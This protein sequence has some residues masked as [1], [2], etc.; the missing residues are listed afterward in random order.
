M[1]SLWEVEFVLNQIKT[2]KDDVLIFSYFYFARICNKLIDF[3]T[4]GARK[5]LILSAS[6]GCGV[7]LGANWLLSCGAAGQAAAH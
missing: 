2:D 5:S 7:P 4:N 1:Q 6:P 3:V